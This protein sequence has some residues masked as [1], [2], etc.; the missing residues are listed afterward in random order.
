MAT[1]SKCEDLAALVAPRRPACS[2]QDRQIHLWTVDL[3]AS[4]QVEQSFRSLLSPD[5]LAR[6]DRFRLQHLR[7][8]FILTRG[9]LRSI[10][11]LYLDTLPRAIQIFYGAAGKPAIHS[12]AQLQFNVSHSGDRA[13]FAFT[14]ACE[15]GIDLEKLRPISHMQDIANRFFCP[16]E[17]AELMSLPEDQRDRAFFLCWTR[18]EAYI[19][20]T[21]QGLSAALDSFRVSLNPQRP[22]AFV[23]INQSVEAARGWTLH[24]FE[25]ARNYVAAL[26][27]HDSE[28]SIDVF[29]VLEPNQLLQ[30]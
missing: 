1:A 10:L 24:S 19:K 11:A 26:A 15:L 4:E 28:R 25:A 8:S 6:A 2:L 29:P 16:A 23:H 17:A 18:K 27:Y 5:E 21:G 7:R 20:A 14:P 13:I 22:A 30:L 3:Q 12:Q 9:C